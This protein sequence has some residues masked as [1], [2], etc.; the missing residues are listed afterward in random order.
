[1]NTLRDRRCYVLP[2]G[3]LV[4]ASAGTNGEWRLCTLE[5]WEHGRGSG[6]TAA[7][8]G[9]VL[10]AGKPTGWIVGDLRA[11]PTAMPERDRSGWNEPLSGPLIRASQ[12]PRGSRVPR[13]LRPEP[14]AHGAR[15]LHH[16]GL[17]DHPGRA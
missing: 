14:D 1:M 9:R 4:V 5:E 6:Y 15:A 3:R 17:D 10:H 8:D 13:F 11:M 16:S 12:Q 7:T 2:N